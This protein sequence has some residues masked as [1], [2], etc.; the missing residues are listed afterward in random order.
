MN[1]T[2]KEVNFISPC[3]VQ[4]CINEKKLIHCKHSCGGYEKITDKGEIKCVKCGISNLFIDCLFQCENHS[5]KESST[6]GVAHA[7]NIIKQLSVKPEEQLFI[8][9]L[10]TKVGQ[11]FL[12]HNIFII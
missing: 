10:I 6:Q 8:A 9:L 2:I 7:L 12:N 5:F 4:D 1:N 3:P 11:Q